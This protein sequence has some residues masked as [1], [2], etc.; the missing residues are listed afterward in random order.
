[1]FR[2]RLIALLL[3]LGTLLV[4]LPAVH[5]SFVNYD[6][7]DYIT[8]NEM[9]NRG[10]T[11]EG[12]RWAFTT[13]HA[14]NWH[15]LTWL[16]H[17]LDCQLFVG[18]AGC[19]HLVNILFHAANV[20]LLFLWILRAT[21]K[22]GPAAFIAALFAFHPLHVES[23][24]W[25]S[26]LKDVLSTFFALL[27]LHAYT[28]YAADGGR[29]DLA[30]AVVLFALGL[31][32]K[33][34]LVTVPFVLLLLDI[35]PFQRLVLWSE[36]A[37]QNTGQGTVRPGNLAA[38]FIEKIPFFLLTIVSCVVT[39]FAQRQGEAV[40]SFAS[41]PFP[42][43]LEN[44]T[45]ATAGYLRQIFWPSGLC[46][47]YPLPDHI[48]VAKVVASAAGLLAITFLAWQ[49]RGARPWFL[50]GW[51][52]FLGTLIP[53]IGLVQV[54]AQAMADRY[55]YI[56]S[57]GLFLALVFLADDLWSRSTQQ[58]AHSNPLSLVP[59][60]AAV[61]ISAGCIV[62]TENQLPYW[63]DSEALFRRAI[64]VTRDNDVALINLGVALDVQGR[65]SE[66]LDY[67]RQ[68]EKLASDRYQ[69]HVNLGNILDKLGLPDASVAEYRLA[70]RA[71]PDD[72]SIH[73]TLGTELSDIGQYDE[74]LHEFTAA[75]QLDPHF[76]WS[77]YQ[78]ARVFFRLG[79]DTNALTELNIA[80]NAAPNN[81]QLL[82]SVAHY[83]AANANAGA[84][85]GRMAVSLA[86]RANQLSGNRQPMVFDIL[87]MAL[88][89][90]GDFTNAQICAQN[91]LA[92]ASAG[93]LQSATAISNRLVLYQNNRPW[94]ESFLATNRL[95]AH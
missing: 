71:R 27:T 10:F 15:P 56:P 23:V 45:L 62:V 91:A 21:G 94:H 4:Y 49:W 24:A 87:G 82:A 38:L 5:Y 81:Y 36:P 28:R 92:L 33:P 58:A 55:M 66:A 35:W 57:I 89:E 25:I 14:G 42:Y 43:R 85:D 29:R 47:L 86:A 37:G 61:L 18:N 8:E 63:Q 46:A 69:L 16:V 31:L 12:I 40:V 64:A 74:A 20:A 11:W 50:I 44:S 34:M 67:Y 72:P 76:P 68:A 73:N 2:P 51:L 59:I 75:E 93:G 13:F 7:T 84:R 77:H 52:W 17:M 39:F 6:D 41:F 19:H 26:E 83:L 48:P 95:V 78:R 30:L 3:A 60:G 1:M 22:T 53:V 65:Y 9:V 79:Q 80:L 54:G 70:V 88:A 90:T 32:A